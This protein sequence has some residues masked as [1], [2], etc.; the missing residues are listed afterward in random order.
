M[1]GSPPR[2]AQRFLSWYCK[3]HLHDSIRGDLDEQFYQN[4]PNYGASRAKLLYWLSVIRFMNRF[5]MKRDRHTTRSS[6]A[7]LGMLKNNLIT[8][9]RFLGR[10]RGITI[11]N[12]FGLVLGFSTFLLILLFVNHELSY[13]QFHRNNEH[14]F[15]VNFSYQDNAGNFTTLVNSPPAL[16]PGIRGK[17]PEVN[18]IS[19]MRYAMNCLF[20]NGENRFYEDHGYFADSLFLE[21]LQFELLSGNP[22]TVLDQPN[23][24]VLTKDLALKYFND[25]DPVGAT[26]LYNNSIPLKV[27]GVLSSIP[28]NSHLNFNFLISFPTYSVPEGYASDL[29][30]STWLGFLTYIE[31]IPNSDPRLFEEKMIQHFKAL[32]PENQN[33]MIP[34]AQKLSSIYLDSDGMVDDL[35]SHIRSGNQ[36]SVNTLMMVAIMILAISGFNFSNITHALSIN[37]SKSIGIMKVLGANK[38]SILAQLLTESL[39]LTFICQVLSFGVILLLFPTISQFMKWEFKLGLMEISKVVP[40][41]IGVGIVIGLVS[42]LY[43]ALKL[44]GFDVIKSLKG[45]LKTVTRNPFQ[46]KNILVLLQFSI[47][48]ALISATI[49]ATQQI[50]YLRNKETGYNAANVILI[51]MLPEDMSRYYEVYKERLIQNSSVISVSRSERVVGDPWPF[52]SIRTVDQDPEMSKRVFFNLADYDYFETMRIPLISGRF[53]AQEYLNDPTNSIIINQ[54]AVKYLGL[55]EPVGKQ[56]HFFDLDGP[57]TIVGIVEDFNYTTLHQEVGPAVVILP[58]IDLEYM[59]VR[60]APNNPGTHIEILE[61]TWKQ[62]SQSTPL[63]WRFLND[64]I[65]QLYQ[66]EEKLSYMIQ[67]LAVL[68]VLLASLGLYGIVAFMINNR[69]KE[70]GV[71]KVLGASVHSLYSLFVRKYIFLI[72]LAMVMVLPLIHYLLNAWLD[73]FA[74]HVNISWWIYPLATLFLIIMILITITFQ[75]LRAVQTNPTVLLRD[76]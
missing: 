7:S 57:R 54:L 5:T 13:D 25:P 10:N 16:A 32:T 66:S 58:F 36:F 60:F 55:K 17:F 75:I 4:Q 39:I 6:Y 67:T 1:K 59:Y 52:S 21:I 19:R 18:K 3:N 71:R 2:L 43:P 69:V 14:V 8:S 12:I 73:D 74:Y 27:T 15:R 63:E 33:P 61:N 30:S 53:F 50:N 49:I 22:G 62:V 20:S 47:S 35:A 37:R 45:S 76:E 11:I 44:T 65:E 41:I 26:L 72:F 23:S 40:V 51:K 42:G 29:T 9:I 68:A 64:D 56:V 70:V 28:T 38:K 34:I 48:I 24:I 46:L 31:L